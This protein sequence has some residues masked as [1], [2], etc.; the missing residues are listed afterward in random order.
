MDR[1]RERSGVGMTKKEIK[2]SDKAA[3]LSDLADVCKRHNL[4]LSHED[5]HGSFIV[6]DY[7]SRNIEWLLEARLDE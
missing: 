3:F 1:D 6:E 7:D 4:S 5:G 2:A